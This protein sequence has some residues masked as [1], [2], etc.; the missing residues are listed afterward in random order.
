MA[1]LT[2]AIPTFDRPAWLARTIQAL[3]PQLGP[4]VDILVLDNQSTPSADESL[5]AL[6][7][8][9]PAAPITIVRHR[10]NVGSNS[11]VLRC[12]EFANSEWVWTL[13]DDDHPA[14]D[15]VRLILETIA[16][17]PDADYLNFCSTSQPSRLEYEARS[18]DEFFDRCDSFS[19]TIFISAGVYR[20][21]RFVRY[22]QSALNYTHTNMPQ[23]VL[24]IAGLREGRKLVFSPCFIVG[25][26]IAPVEQRWPYY[27][28]FQFME[29]IEVLPTWEMQRKM[30][31]L[32]DASEIAHTPMKLVRW[33]LFGQLHNPD[34]PSALFFLARGAWMR[35]QIASS[36][37][38]AWKWRL[39]SLVA[40]RLHRHQPAIWRWWGRWHRW[41]HGKP[42][43]PLTTVAGYRGMFLHTPDVRRES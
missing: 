26:Q 2:I 42:L 22:I 20:R 9:S 29:I 28:F 13:G 25:W 16:T 3:L 15:A 11:N 39:T 41:R 4:D 23:L 37:L 18:L 24:L 35:A 5:S 14:P 10:V 19:N 8:E 32:L 6:L 43:T 21:E 17:H 34:N 27:F 36:V 1:R 40:M 38:S 7:P 12:L 30:A 31:K 33:A